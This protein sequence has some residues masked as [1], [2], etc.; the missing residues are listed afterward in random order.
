LFFAGHTFPKIIFQ[1][2]GTWYILY[3]N[4]DLL[5]QGKKCGYYDFKIENGTVHI[6][7][8]ELELRFEYTNISP[9]KFSL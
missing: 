2:I 5:E 4:V 7:K 8:Y 9:T 6:N 3:G 1:A